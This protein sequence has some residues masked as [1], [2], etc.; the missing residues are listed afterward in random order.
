[1]NS[2]NAAAAW[3]SRA[4]FVALPVGAVGFACAA[5][6]TWSNVEF[7]SGGRA[8]PL[9]DWTS[10]QTGT[11]AIAAGTA[12]ALSAAGAAARRRCW[13]TSV[14]LLLAFACGA[15]FS[16]SASLDRAGSQ[17]DQ[18]INKRQAH[19]V[20][21]ARTERRLAQA[22]R[23]LK[24]ALVEIGAECAG[25]PKDRK[26]WPNCRGGELARDQAQATIRR[27]EAEL[28]TAGTEMPEDS[29]GIRIAAILPFLTPKQVAT[30]Q[31]ATWPVALFLLGNFLIAFACLALTPTAHAKTERHEARPII[32]ITP[33][34]VID[35]L[36][37]QKRAITNRELAVLAQV[38][39]ATAHRQVKALAD[40]GRVMK[41]REGRA[42]MIRYVA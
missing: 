33:D 26:G 37:R 14:G 27:L 22:Q 16:L 21:I 9:G 35:A 36:R 20:A 38:S 42:M 12:I 13:L 11:V 28:A 7:V 23:D 40:A 24:D 41:Q 17:R 19:N 3:L 29:M 34:P 18:A 15:A 6:D 39:E 4:L 8:P 31:P 30:F 1:M 10:L 32:D 2:I 25:A 5:S